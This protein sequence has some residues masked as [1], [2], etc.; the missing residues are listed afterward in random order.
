MFRHEKAEAESHGRSP[1]NGITPMPISQDPLATEGEATPGPNDENP[2]DEAPPAR[3]NESPTQGR[4]P[5]AFDD[6]DEDVDDVSLP[7]F[8]FF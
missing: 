4:D 5:Y 1:G 2:Y 8:S 3:L 7:G 6:V